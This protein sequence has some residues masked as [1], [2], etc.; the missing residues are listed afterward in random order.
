MRG[1]LQSLDGLSVSFYTG[2][3]GSLEV[4]GTFFV[5]CRVFPWVFLGLFGAYAL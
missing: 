5:F 3:R 1:V 2:F 4:S